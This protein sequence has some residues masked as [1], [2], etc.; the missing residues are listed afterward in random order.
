MYSP[1]AG[2]REPTAPTCPRKGSAGVRPRRAFFF[3][4]RR[5][6]YPRFQAV[7]VPRH[8]FF[9]VGGPRAVQRA[10]LVAAVALAAVAVPASP[11]PVQGGGVQI[12]P[13]LTVDRD[14]N[15]VRIVARVAC[16]Q[17]F[18]EQL[19]CLAGTREHE[20]LL[21]IAVAPSGVHAALLA[22]GLEPGHP[23]RWSASDGG[24]VATAAPEGPE[25]EAFV[26][27][28]RGSRVVEIPLRTWTSGPD[29]LAFA[30][31]LVFAGSEIRPN[32]PSLARLRGPGEHY[33][34]D[35]TGSVIGLVTFG[36]EVIAPI[37]VH[38]DRA[39][40]AEPIYAARTEAM[41]LPGTAV[42]LVLRP[43]ASAFR[44]VP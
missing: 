5:R 31:P 19:V 22:L 14:R 20:S 43:A 18:L 3:P 4:G 21:S 9:P 36:D 35:L 26:R 34:A 12:V 29:G 38:P 13:G 7:N 39:E 32:P 23:G 10:R 37:A 40:V 2:R 15:E 27:R 25:I 24:G 30:P 6:G 33:V 41:P 17:G 42:T 1:E 11:V 8:K 28:I 44:S 16:H